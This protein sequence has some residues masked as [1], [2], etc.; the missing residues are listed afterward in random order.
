[1]LTLLTQ[2]WAQ[3]RVLIP[4]PHPLA[5]QPSRLRHA[6]SFAALCW[7]QGKKNR[8]KKKQTK[9]QTKPTS[10]TCSNVWGAETPNTPLTVPRG[11]HL[12]V[13]VGPWPLCP[14]CPQPVLAVPQQGAE[15]ALLQ[16]KAGGCQ[17]RGGPD[18]EDVLALQLLVGVLQGEPRSRNTS[19]P[20]RVGPVCLWWL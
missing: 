18:D 4:H 14:G 10:Q 16:P 19:W 6:K 11:Q 20:S 3:T 9:A 12:G 1:M 2:Q 8:K 7:Q 17:L 5:A 13:Q 15:P